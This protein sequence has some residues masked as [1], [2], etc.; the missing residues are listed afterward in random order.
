[1]K[2][3]VILY[4]LNR[5]Q[6]E[7]ET[8]FDSELTINSIS[9]AL[10]GSF[11]V[12][13][14]E[15]VKDF[16]WIERVREL[17]PDLVFNICEG[18]HGPARESVYAAIL[19]QLEFNYSGPDSTNLLV[20]HNKFLAKNLVKD[21][22]R[23]PYGYI[24]RNLNDIE[25]L[26][27]IQYPVMV[28]L[29]SEGSSMGMNEKSVVSNFIELQ[30]QVKW[31]LNKY[32]RNILIEKYIEGKDISMV[33]VE[34]LGALGPCQVECESLFYDYE[35]KIIKDSTVDIFP[36]DGTYK[37]LKET[38]MEIVKR[39]DIKGY[40]KLDF[41]MQNGEYYLIE[42]NSQVSFHPTGEFIT[43]CKKDGY[44]FNE[45]IRYIVENALK[46]NTKIN[47]TGIGE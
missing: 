9:E 12:K 20:C 6:Y 27:N 29:N 41:R 46:T 4:N 14:V 33:Y 3:V 21:I 7:Y 10:K 37:K 36:L 44:D 26:K 17:K 42:V 32:N 11:E 5:N 28:K 1:M 23:V 38:V 15:A 19:E 18:F 43:C 35:M 13:K 40:A 25:R 45:I 8:E 2:R 22:T 31:L 34:G 24:V 47:S 39:L 16:S 30:E